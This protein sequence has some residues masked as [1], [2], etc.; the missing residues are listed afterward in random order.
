MKTRLLVLTSLLALPLISACGQLPNP[1]ERSSD[2]STVFAESDNIADAAL[3]V[4]NLTTLFLDVNDEYDFNYYLSFSD[5]R[6]L[7]IS[8]YTF[9]STD[10][11]VL[12]IENYVAKAVGEGFCYVN[13]SGP[14]LK[15]TYKQTVYVGSVAGN[16]VLDG[17]VGSSNVSMNLGSEGFT[18]AVQEGT[19]HKDDIAAYNGTGTWSREAVCFLALT[20][21]G[22]APTEVRSIEN[23]L[24]AFG[25][26]NDVLSQI[27]TNY[28]GR[29]NYE[30]GVGIT[31]D[32]FFH[33]TL[34]K[35]VNAK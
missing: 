14:G 29:L 2:H 8:D 21:N 7:H 11:S 27:Q 33:D 19:Y 20:F 10:Q 12:T 26:P 13:V 4:A 17:K 3:R 1:A 15:K 5:G 18:L 24:A 35:L 16:Y 6:E 31:C 32:M 30:E 23:A 22:A 25:L 9:V 34:I 28:Y